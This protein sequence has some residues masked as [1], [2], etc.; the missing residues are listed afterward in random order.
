MTWKPLRRFR[1]GPPTQDATSKRSAYYQHLHG[2]TD[3]HMLI[4]VYLHSFCGDIYMRILGTTLMYVALLT[5]ALY[6]YTAFAV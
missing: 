1:D 3:S 2:L 4:S 6:A 5:L